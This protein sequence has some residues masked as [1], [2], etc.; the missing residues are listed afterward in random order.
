[1]TP[2]AYETEERV[3]AA[4][5]RS[6]RWL[7][8]GLYLVN[9]AIHLILLGYPP[10]VF[11]YNLDELHLTYSCLDR[12]LGVPSWIMAEPSSVLQLVSVPAILAD[13]LLRGLHSSSQPGV[14]NKF[15]AYLSA[16]YADPRHHVIL[17]RALVAIIACMG[18]ALLYA[19]CR[20]LGGSRPASLLCGVVLSLHPAFFDRSLQ[21]AGDSA[22]IA[23][24][25]G[26][27]LLL[28]LTH[29]GPGIKYLAGF[30]YAMAVVFKFT[31][32]SSLAILLAI[33][34]AEHDLRDLRLAA[35]SLAR[36]GLGAV[37]GILLL[38]PYVWTEPLRT[39]KAILGN[40]NKTGSHTDW[41]QFFQKFRESA[42]IAFVV[43]AIA[44]A[45]VSLWAARRSPAK[46]LILPLLCSLAIMCVP[47]AL[48]A[49]VAYPRYFIPL[50]LPPLLCFVLLAGKSLRLS[51]AILAVLAI[52]MAVT[53]VRQQVALRTPS[54]LVAALKVLPRLP[55]GITAYMPED[56]AMTFAFRLPQATYRRISA[57]AK[58]ELYGRQGVL[59]FMRSRGIGD[60]ASRILATDFNE[61][62]QAN[63]AHTAA[64]AEAK[65]NAAIGADVYLYYSY[66]TFATDRTSWAYIDQARAIELFRGQDAAAILLNSGEEKSGRVIWQGGA[67]AW[68]TND[69]QPGAV[70]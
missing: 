34:W 64:A 25:L 5:F 57:H 9:L 17:V 41:M 13:F 52:A 10:D 15:S 28:L 26:A 49:N 18:P 70:Q 62:E 66:R 35:K 50:A 2:I 60:D 22:G 20:R 38:W 58:D 54:E 11:F 7:A 3:M 21:A 36:F 42:G 29:R 53:L 27:A 46:G 47:L 56:A 4:V 12:F 37:L 31:N 1:M 30:L 40:V 44:V 8:L 59:A 65:S 68:Y 39:A 6:D 51:S 43:F 61:E 48:R 32:A 69:K 16:A 33:M 63:A 67:W 24:L 55:P 45:L 14:I 23:A 19:M